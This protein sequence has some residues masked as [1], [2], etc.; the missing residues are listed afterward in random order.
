MCKAICNIYLIYFFIFAL[1]VA[2][3]RFRGNWEGSMIE[4]LRIV[5]QSIGLVIVC[6]IVVMLVT[7]VA[8]EMID[9]E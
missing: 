3:I 5:L 4:I 1:R 2:V 6:G 9:S 7:R 8:L